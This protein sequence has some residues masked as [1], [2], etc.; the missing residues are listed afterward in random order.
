MYTKKN[1]GLKCRVLDDGGCKEGVCVCVCLWEREGVCDVED[2]H[3]V[4]FL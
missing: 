2:L 1:I 4:F 3:S